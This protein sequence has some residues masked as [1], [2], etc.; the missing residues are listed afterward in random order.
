MAKATT[1]KDAIKTFEER[2]GVVATE[3]EKVTAAARQVAFA[4]HASTALL[5]APLPCP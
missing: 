5:S 1:I 4:P 3:A 2:K